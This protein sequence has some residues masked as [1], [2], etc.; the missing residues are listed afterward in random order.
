M[1]ACVRV[2]QPLRAA[3]STDPLHRDDTASVLEFK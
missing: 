3:R 2:Y 1:G